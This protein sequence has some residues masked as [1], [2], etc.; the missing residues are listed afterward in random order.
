M[1]QRPTQLLWKHP[2]SLAQSIEYTPECLLVRL[3]HDILCL[4]PNDGRVLFEKKKLS[5]IGYQA[6]LHPGE[7]WLLTQNDTSKSE[8]VCVSPSTGEALWSISFSGSAYQAS[9]RAGVLSA[10][11]EKKVFVYQILRDSAG[12]TP[13][14]APLH[15][16]SLP[17]LKH[18][19]YYNTFLDDNG[20]LVGI[21][22][23]SRS[24]MWSVQSGEL[25]WDSEHQL[26][27]VMPWGWFAQRANRYEVDLFDPSGN[28]LQTFLDPRCAANNPHIHSTNGRGYQVLQTNDKYIAMAS[29]YF[30]RTSGFGADGVFVLRRGESTAT[31]LGGSR[32]CVYLEDELVYI[33]GYGEVQLLNQ[34]YQPIWEIT[35]KEWESLGLKKTI[36]SHLLPAEDKLFGISFE[37]VFCL[38]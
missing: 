29:K 20:R 28:L 31:K 18:G 25:L 9:A 12:S 22:S 13:R 34:S 35:T 6:I 19:D 10:P 7:L 26:Q 30:S 11:F 5:W 27:K 15:E 14:L 38:A 21:S 16:L 17:A 1:R 3:L 32:P 37:E 33:G 24:L 4:S 2:T 8:L 23:A 36:V